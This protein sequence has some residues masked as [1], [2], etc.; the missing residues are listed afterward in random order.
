ME[1]L[2]KEN[3]KKHNAIIEF[4]KSILDK[5]RSMFGNNSVEVKKLEK[6]Y[7]DAIKTRETGTNTDEKQYSKQGDVD[8]NELLDRYTTK[9]YNDYGWIAVNDVLSK[10]EWSQY[11]NKLREALT[12]NTPKNVHGE[13]IITVG[14][15]SSDITALVYVKGTASNPIVTKVVRVNP[16][17]KNQ[18]NVQSIIGDVLDYERQGYRNPYAFIETYAEEKILV[19]NKIGDFPTFQEFVAT[20][21]GEISRKNNTNSG[22]E[23]NGAGSTRTNT[24]ISEAGVDTSAFSNAEKSKSSD[25]QYSKQND[26]DDI[27]YS[28]MGDLMS[29]S[30]EA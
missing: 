13:K 2:A 27:R 30:L 7:L 3:P 20:R 25:T 1:E 29:L 18:L 28:K 19:Q 9:T 6:L 5:I 22:S 14:N 11:N 21:K 26:N 17:I 8:N 24:E 23:Q 4:L 16:N 12:D 15:H 10:N